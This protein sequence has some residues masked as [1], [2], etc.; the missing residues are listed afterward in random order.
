[1]KTLLERFEEKVERVPE[2]TCHIW[3]AWTNTSGY[4]QIR[5]NGKSA[6][7]H[8][9]SYELV[10][11][12]IPDG[13]TMDHLCRNRWCVNPYHL[14]IVTMRENVLRGISFA[15]KNAKK[16]QCPKGHPYNRINNRGARYCRQ[17]ATK[18]HIKYYQ[19]RKAKIAAYMREYRRVHKAE[20][21]ECTRKS[22]QTHKTK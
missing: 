13:M 22:R 18:C 16:T 3:M 6:M 19:P 9:I 12:P 5:A 7:A 21:D 1:M 4:G 15:A 14:E 20:I 10:R 2:L 8:K 11:G 17:C